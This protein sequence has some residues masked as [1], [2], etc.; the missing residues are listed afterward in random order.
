MDN[1]FGLLGA[2]K[3]T[4]E[5]DS[6]E[7]KNVQVASESA[8]YKLEKQGFYLRFLNS[9]QK[10]GETSKVESRYTDLMWSLSCTVADTVYTVTRYLQSPELFQLERTRK[11]FATSPSVNF[12]TLEELEM[13]VSNGLR[14]TKS[15]SESES[16]YNY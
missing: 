7:K 13:Y 6:L 15:K 2:I 9:M 8:P 11:G 14:S 4:T 16:N 5:Q 12:N 1:M 3:R 10:I